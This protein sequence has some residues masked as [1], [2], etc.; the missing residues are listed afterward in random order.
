MPSTD[1]LLET[2]QG[3]QAALNAAS[4]AAS[5]T[6]QSATQPWND[7]LVKFLSIGVLG[8]SGIS[9]LL[10]TILLLRAG[11]PPPQVLKIFGIL[12]IIGISA[13]LLVVGYSNSQLTPIIGL[14]GAIAGYLLGKDVSVARNDA[15]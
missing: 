13:L 11:S 5:Q 10:A 9:L 15:T 12:S 4:S 3:A 2:M 14:F 8:F 7:E 1:T 6:V